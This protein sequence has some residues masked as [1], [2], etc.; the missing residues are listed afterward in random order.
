MVIQLRLEG[1][2]TLSSSKVSDSNLY[3]S[4]PCF[5]VGTDQT[6]GDRL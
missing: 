3:S 5:S 2:V 1:D 4:C 6:D